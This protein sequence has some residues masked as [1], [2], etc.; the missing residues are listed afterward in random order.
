MGPNKGLLLYFP[1]LLLAVPGLGFLMRK[2]DARGTALGLV[3]PVVFSIC[4]YSVYSMWHG[5]NGWGPRYLLP[6]VPLLAAA[7]G[8]V[9]TRSRRWR[10]GAIC[11]LFLGFLVNALGVLESEAIATTYLIS[12]EPSRLSR[13]EA[14]AY[15]PY[16]VEK[17]DNGELRLSLLYTAP[18]DAAFAPIRTHAFLLA[19]RLAAADSEE[20]ARRIASPP[21]LAVRPDVVPHRDAPRGTLFGIVE[22]DLTTPFRWPFLGRVA[23]TPLDERRLTFVGAWENA[24]RDQ[25]LRLLDLGRAH[26]AV[27]LARRYD[28]LS[29]SGYSGA[30]VAE[31]LRASGERRE[32]ETFVASL[33]EERRHSPFLAVVE[34]LAARDRGDESAARQRV[35]YALGFLRDPAL[36]SLL[37]GPL[38][39]WP[40]GFRQLTSPLM[41]LPRFLEEP[42]RSGR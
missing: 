20:L 36:A 2:A 29:R 26:A 17:R 16:L 8:S 32:L 22:Y 13:A 7:A 38:A 18:R 21:W 9:A 28:D 6:L 15:P 40:P 41:A 25:V 11:C 30:L 42:G 10:I 1:L 27:P 19:A 39:S 4:L 33:S 12:G 37:N 5:G 31:A 23:T 3:G 35:A 34:A 24:L 14:R